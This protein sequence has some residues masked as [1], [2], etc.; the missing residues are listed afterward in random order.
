M[1]RA[2]NIQSSPTETTAS[3]SRFLLLLPENFHHFPS[4]DSD[5]WHSSRIPDLL[6]DCQRSTSNSTYSKQKPPMASLP[7]PH[8]IFFL[9]ISLGLLVSLGLQGWKLSDT[10]SN[11]I[12]HHLP[13]LSLKCTIIILPFHTTSTGLANWFSSIC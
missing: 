7:S 10:I 13:S 2:S 5:C 11:S 12:C 8:R 3:L 1:I 9:N 6:L 4:P